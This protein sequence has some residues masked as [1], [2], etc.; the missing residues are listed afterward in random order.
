MQGERRSI[1]NGAGTT[2][3]STGTAPT[4]VGKVDVTPFNLTYLKTARVRVVGPSGLSKLTRC[5]LESGSQTSFV[6]KCIRDALKLD[7]IDR[8]NLAVSALESFPITSRSRR[9]VRL[10]LREIWTNFNTTITAFKSTYEF[11]PHP[12]VPR[13]INTTTHTP[14]LQFADLRD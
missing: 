1:C 9:L 2:T 14:K 5:V 7:V 6:S 11:L 8:R 4:T 10:D 12:T 3:R 13:D